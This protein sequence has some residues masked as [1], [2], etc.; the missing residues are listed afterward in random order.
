MQNYTLNVETYLND[1]VN[2]QLDYYEKAANKAK[3][4][5]VMIQTTII[6]LGIL[7]P[8]VVN[9]PAQWGTIDVGPYLR[10]LITVVSLTLALLTG[11]ANFRKFGDLWL[12]YRM[13]EE[14]L[15]TEKFLFLTGSGKY[16][17]ASSPFAQFVQSIEEIV[18]SEHI[19]FRSIIEETARPSKE[20][21]NTG[22]E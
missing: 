22:E 20:G 21:A 6:I 7:V 5:H 18:S 10:G 13:T 19:K 17:S 8:V 1:R 12:T 11:I 4:T 16:H 14:L 15:K 2:G 9:I 3:N